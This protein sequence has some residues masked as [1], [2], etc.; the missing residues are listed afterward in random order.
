MKTAALNIWTPDSAS[1]A[2]YDIPVLRVDKAVQEYDENLRFGRN[3]ETGQWCIFRIVRG[4]APLPILGFND[5]PHPDDA[6]RR[7]YS[8]D[9]Q[10]RG[11]EILTEMNRHNAE[12]EKVQ[13]DAASEADG[14]AAEVYEH[15][16]RMMGKTPYTKSFRPRPNRMG[17][18]A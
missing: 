1:T 3:E 9:A 17:G 5:I 2:R 4:M 11:E 15:A 18:Y 6:L 10:R 14:L 12:L 13:E 7:L 16:F 8:V